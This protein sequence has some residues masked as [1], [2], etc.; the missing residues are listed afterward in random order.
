VDGA[1]MKAGVAT[2]PDMGPHLKRQRV[3]GAEMHKGVMTRP[4]DGAD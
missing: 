4:G 1:E 3:D 2:K